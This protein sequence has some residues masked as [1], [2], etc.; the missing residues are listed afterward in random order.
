MLAAVLLVLC[1]AYLDLRREQRS[2]LADFTDEQTV[3]ANA[4]AATLQVRLG[5]AVDDLRTAASLDQPMDFLRTLIERGRY[6]EAEWVPDARPSELIHG[7]ER[8]LPIGPVRAQVLVAL[9]QGARW[10][11]LGSPGGTL[12]G[13]AAKGGIVLLV[14]SDESLFGGLARAAESDDAAQRIVAFDPRGHAVDLTP[15]RSGWPALTDNSEARALVNSA[16]P[17]TTRI[18][19]RPAAAALGIG[20]R[21]AVMASA[22]VQIADG[23]RWS[24]AVI[25][26][27]RRVRDRQS[28][29]AWRLV[30]ATGLAS[31]LVALFAVF[32]FRQERS[33]LALA[34]QLRLAEATAALRERSEKIVDAIPLGVMALD[35]A[36]RVTSVNAF[37]SER[38]VA[39]AGS[40]AAAMPGIDAAE[41]AS[42]EALLDEAQRTRQPGSTRSLKLRLGAEPR[43]VDAYA[44]PLGLPLAGVD[45]FLLLD[46]RTELRLLERNLQ[47]AEKLATIGTLA[48]GVAHEVGTPLGVISGRAEQLM[49]RAR[50]DEPTVK[51]LTSIIAQVDKVSTTIRQLLDFARSKPIEATAV[52]PTS[53]LETASALLEHRFRHAKVS[54]AIDAPP[55]VPAMAGDPGQIDQ[56]LVN[57]LINAVDACSAGG[58]VKASAIA[59]DSQVE[60]AISDDGCGIAPEHLSA[61]LDPFFTTKKRGQGTGLGLSI[62]ADIV[63]NHGGTLHID[64]TVGRG[65]TVRVRLPLARST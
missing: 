29:G 5:R 55:T 40:L 43:E 4:L 1:L 35:G 13:A 42:I 32:L 8:T 9:R 49:A 45:C 28:V 57:L 38:R 11:A 63:K 48:A 65:T 53:A 37:L 60:I 22:P 50:G 21:L 15:N 25:S 19:S 27:A 7:A 54:L 58:Q 56:V 36:G 62:A 30:A 14:A 23:L 17:Q 2:A 20:R 51:G 26:S 59:V 12:L 47:R 64:S 52:T 61:V 24:V 33:A 6:R 10:M 46:D 3:L 44:I 34:D 39:T 16:G 31:F 41:L 18:L